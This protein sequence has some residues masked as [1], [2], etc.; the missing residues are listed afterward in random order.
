LK[1]WSKIKLAIFPTAGILLLGIILWYVGIDRLLGVLSRASLMWLILSALTTLPTYLL[2]AW[3]L[4]LLLTPVKNVSTS[5][6]FWATAV[7]FMV[8]FL[9]PVRL[10]ELVRAYILSAKE[11]IDFAP[12]FSSIVVERTLDI[13]GL[14]TLGLLLLLFLPF[15]TSIP[16]NVLNAFMVAGVLIT[17]LLT[18]IIVGTRQE[19]ATLGFIDRILSPSIFSYKKRNIVLSIVKGLIDGARAVGQNP[20]LFLRTLI[21]TY[22][23]WLFQL[24]GIWFIFKAFDYPA[25]LIVILTGATIV[26]FTFILPAAPGYIGTYE[27]YWILI[28]L[29]LGL[30]DID[31]LLAMGLAR[32]LIGL[33][34]ALVL[35]C[36]GMMWLGLSFEE[37]FKIRRTEKLASSS[38]PKPFH[39]IEY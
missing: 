32:H 29:G 37:V 35:G 17:I 11:K 12:S 24:L 34:T 21:L 26:M 4:K 27:T 13:L 14:L 38:S 10:G 19:K 15:G 22:F 30:T 23:L 5:T 39:H 28:F 3:R 8:N 20:K 18:A 6:T 36:I 9:I 2:R 31:W 1:N 33:V 25:P 16:P 7:G